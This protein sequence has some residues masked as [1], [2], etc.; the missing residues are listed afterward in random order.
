MRAIAKKVLPFL[1]INWLLIGLMYFVLLRASSQL[2]NLGSSELLPMFFHGM[3]LTIVLHGLVLSVGPAVLALTG[4][5]RSA[6]V[7][8]LVLW[9][10]YLS[11]TG[12]IVLMVS[13][14][15]AALALLLKAKDADRQWQDSNA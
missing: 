4:R 2:H 13:F 3:P 6:W 12:T 8:W 7:V 9:A 15:V 11:L 14:G 10:G 1:L 5:S